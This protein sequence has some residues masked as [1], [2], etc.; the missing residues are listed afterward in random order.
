MTTTTHG[1]RCQHTILIQRLDEVSRQ[2][3]LTL[4][5]SLALERAIEKERK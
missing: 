4:P 3:A 2:R 1:K 5:E